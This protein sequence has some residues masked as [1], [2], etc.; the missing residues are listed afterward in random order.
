MITIKKIRDVPPKIKTKDA[1]AL[2]R[3]LHAEL[4]KDP[5]RCLTATGKTQNLIMFYERQEN[6]RVVH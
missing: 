3:H 4:M 5:T 1:I 6:E 2:L